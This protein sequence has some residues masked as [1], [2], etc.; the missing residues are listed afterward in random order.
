[1]TTST[2]TPRPC[3]YAASASSACAIASGA[4]ATFSLAALVFGSPAWAPL[5]F[6]AGVCAALA[7][8][9]S[10][11]AIRLED[12]RKLPDRLVHAAAAATA[13]FRSPSTD[14]SQDVPPAANRAREEQEIL[15]GRLRQ[16]RDT[17]RVRLAHA[18]RRAATAVEP[19]R[20]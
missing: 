18:L 17:G 3:A 1:M 20:D 15:L 10:T 12:L 6:S 13:A 8:G 11:G 2:T 7:W 9:F 19:S 4:L 5:L 14:A 16:A